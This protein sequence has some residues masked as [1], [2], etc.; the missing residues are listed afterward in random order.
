MQIV[1]D[2]D[3]LIFQVTEGKNVRGNFFPEE[4]GESLGDTKYKEPLKPY[5]KKFHAA[6]ANLVEEIAVATVCEPWMIEEV[7]I[8]FSDPKGNFRGDIYPDYKA[9]RKNGEGRSELFYH[10]RKWATKKYTYGKGLEADDVVA[11]YVREEDYLGVSTD[12]DL[13]YGVP[14]LWFNSHYMHLNLIDT[15]EHEAE[16]F[17]FIQT[18]AG[19]PVDNIKG[20]PRVGHATAIKLLEEF[21]WSWA[22]VVAAYKSKGLTEEDAILTKR[23]VSM[24]QIKPRKDG[25]WKLKMFKPEKR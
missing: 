13:L 6:V 1:I 9:N 8:I 16:R 4:E 19:D 25:K 11:W 22:G 17:N 3:F 5:K 14:G 20:I 7:K 23:L 2:A 18:L 15:G 10:L 24:D 12:K 21:G